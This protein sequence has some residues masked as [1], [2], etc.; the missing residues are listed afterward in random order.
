MG[1]LRLA[2]ETK[3][4]A[5]NTTVLEAVKLMTATGVGAVVVTT[6][7]PLDCQAVGVFTERDLMRRVVNEG[8]NPATTLIREV[9]SSPVRGVLDGV[10]VSE[11]AALMR[12]HRFRHLA[13]VDAGGRFLGMVAL[14]HLLYDLM[15]DLERKVGGLESFMMIDGPGG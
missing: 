5:P 14:R 1:L 12:R 3:Q 2:Q 9:M 4:V 6:G 13:V 11:A 10:S 15:D 8:K 7:G